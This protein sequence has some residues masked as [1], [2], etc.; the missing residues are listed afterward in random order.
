ME[1]LEFYGLKGIWA[2]LVLLIGGVGL[3][4]KYL[5]GQLRELKAT[6]YLHK[7]EEAEKINALESRVQATEHNFNTVKEDYNRLE[8]QNK[9]IMKK[10]DKVSHEFQTLKEQNA[11]IIGWLSGQRESALSKLKG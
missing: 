1:N 9:E 4:C 5:Y 7:S 2:A 11:E 3:A 10:L 6:V 8:D